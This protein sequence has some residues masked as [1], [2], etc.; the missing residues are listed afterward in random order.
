MTVIKGEIPENIN[1]EFRKLAMERFGYE[2]GAISKA[3]E[4]AIMKWIMD[5][6]NRETEEENERLVNNKFYRENKK[7]LYME[8]PNKY[9]TICK[10]N[11]AE[12]GE[13]FFSTV[14]KTKEKYPTIKHC[15]IINTGFEI[16]RRRAG[17]GWQ[18]KRVLV[19]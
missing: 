19:K 3:I 6:K 5:Q 11:I 8:F 10:G 1:Q 17:L 15:L 2:K 13:D 14:Q 16:K 9:I 12:T 7:R 4:E 18:M